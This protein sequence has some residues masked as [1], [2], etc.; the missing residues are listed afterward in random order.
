VSGHAIRLGAACFSG[1]HVAGPYPEDAVYECTREHCPKGLCPEPCWPYHLSAG[2]S[3]RSAAPARIE[4]VRISDY[5]DGISQEQSARRADLEIRR[6]WLHD[7]HDDAVENDWGASVKVIDSLLERVNI[8]FASRQRSGEHIDA[9]SKT[10]EVRNSL[11]QLHRFTNQYKRKP[12]HG[13]VWKWG[14]AGMD[15]RFIVTDNVFVAETRSEGLLLPLVD[16][17]VECRNNRLFWAGPLAAWQQELDDDEGSD[18]LDNRGRVEALA[19]CYTV[20]LKPASQ[21]RAEFLA[22]HWDPLVR[23]WKAAHA[24][25]GSGTTAHGPA[26]HAIHPGE[27]P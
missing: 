13:G 10:F 5:G 14:H 21:S 12:G 8:A 6:V 4:D 19:H 3:V 27:E 22:Q 26:Y 2:L 11:V 18:G 17:V 15:P 16:R 9:R 25:G 1:G 20:V 24:A 23:A 7:L